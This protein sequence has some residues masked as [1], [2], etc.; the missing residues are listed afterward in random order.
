MSSLAVDVTPIVR[1]ELATRLNVD[2][3]HSNV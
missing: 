3:T 1:G 2:L